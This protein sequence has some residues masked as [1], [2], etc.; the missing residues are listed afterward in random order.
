MVLRNDLDRF[1]LVMDVIDRAPT[2][3]RL[4]ALVRQSI[5]DL[6]TAHRAYVVK[7]GALPQVRDWRWPA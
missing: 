2:C 5:V 7:H 3:G 1:H 4:A 6:R